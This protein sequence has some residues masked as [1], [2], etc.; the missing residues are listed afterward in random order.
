MH[1]PDGR[2]MATAT[3]ETIRTVEVAADDRDQALNKLRAEI[4]YRL[5]YC[6]CSG[7]GDDFV[8]LDVRAAR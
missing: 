4:R 2:W 8:E 6:P 7:V 5:E 1:L 3:D